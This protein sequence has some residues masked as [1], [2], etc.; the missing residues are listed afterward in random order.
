MKIANRIQL[1]A[2]NDKESDTAIVFQRAARRVREWR[3][4]HRLGQ[5]AF[6]RLAGVSVGCVQSF[7]ASTRE[8]REANL[9]KMAAAMNLT[10]AELIQDDDPAS[11][12]SNPLLLNLR[13]EDLRLAQHFHHAGADA[14]HAA[15]RFFHSTVSDDRRERIAAVIL[16]LLDAEE[17]E[18]TDLETLIH[19]HRRL[20]VSDK[21]VIASERKPG[22]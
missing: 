10:L 16:R 13:T 2:N 9:I 20:E 17:T 15:K 12:T 4:A 6:A 3:T 11:E 18:F 5:V 21:P 19:G 8:T 1:V 14:K 22:K 7:E